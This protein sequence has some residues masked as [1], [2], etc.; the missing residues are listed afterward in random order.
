M[1]FIARDEAPSVLLPTPRMRK[2]THAAAAIHPLCHGQV[3]TYACNIETLIC[4]HMRSLQD[5]VERDALLVTR[6]RTMQSL[7][8]HINVTCVV[9]VSTRTLGHETVW[10]LISG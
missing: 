7:Q 8:N 5:L 3:S 1:R 2:W 6:P 10:M 4:M 9:C